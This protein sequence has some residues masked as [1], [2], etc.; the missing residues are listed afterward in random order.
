LS[1][2]GGKGERNDWGTM[3][4]IFLIAEPEIAVERLEATLARVP[5]AALLLK[6]GEEDDFAYA[7]RAKRLAKIAQTYNCAVLLDNRPD[8]VR[9]AYVDG[10]HM[11]GGIKA[12]REALEELKPD[13]IVGT[14]DIG[15]RH[16]AMTRGE[17]GIDYLMFGDRDDVD[18]RKMANWWAETFEV[19]SVFC[20]DAA[21]DL[22]GLKSEFA[23]FAQAEWD[24][25]VPGDAP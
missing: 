25:I 4:E 17:L 15:S 1:L 14:G 10:V 11:S 2:F 8:L 21:Q 23:A 5:A 19:P 7:D 3:A 16:E 18:G 9:K 20:G 6:A 12:L 22:S 13:F 24:K